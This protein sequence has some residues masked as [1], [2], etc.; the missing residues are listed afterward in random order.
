MKRFFA[1]LVLISLTLSFPGCTASGSVVKGTVNF[2]YLKA[3]PN[4]T[5]AESFITSEARETYGRENDLRYLLAQ[6]F[7]GPV[8]SELYSPFPTGTA[9][10]DAVLSDCTLEI[11]LSNARFSQKSRLHTTLCLACLAKTCAELADIDT[12]ILRT[13][14]TSIEEAIEII[15]S[16]DDFVLTD[17]CFTETSPQETQ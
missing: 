14:E 10:L 15:F 11:K 1:I 4:Y 9:V 13:E 8:N 5:H 12:I 17:D 7:M 6:Y 2:Y 16:P 3:E